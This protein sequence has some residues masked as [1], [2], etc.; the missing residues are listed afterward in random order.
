[1]AKRGGVKHR[2]SVVEV[3]GSKPAWKL[4]EEGDHEFKYWVEKS[5]SSMA[6]CQ[7]GCGELIKKG[8]LRIGEPLKDPRGEYGVI[9]GWRHLTCTRLKEGQVS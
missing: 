3:E 2:F 7:R 8:T 1:M 6:R 4:W 9:N 5:P